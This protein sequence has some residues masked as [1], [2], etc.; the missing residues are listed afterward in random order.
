MC[1]GII[2]T[3]QREGGV[4]HCT[5]K[6]DPKTAALF[7]RISQGY[8]RCT[9][10]VRAGYSQ[11]SEVMG[12]QNLKKPEIQCAIREALSGGSQA[13]TQDNV[14]RE[15]ARIAF[16][17]PRKLFR[18]DGSPKPIEELDADTAAALAGLEVREEF[19]GTGQDRAFTGY[20]KKYRLANKMGALNSLAKY[21]RLFDTRQEED[22]DSSASGVIL[23]PEV[24][25]E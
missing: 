6:A 4:S 3:E 8:G 14:L 25:E 10:G 7:D 17:D 9:G 20:T 11:T 22:K 1:A 23:M 19:E 2:N 18:E 15:Y 12:Y 24:N 5:K 13:V 21:M 16:F